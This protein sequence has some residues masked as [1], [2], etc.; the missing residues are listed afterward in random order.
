MIHRDSVA[1]QIVDSGMDSSRAPIALFVYNR[2]WH[3]RQTV[4][5]LQKNALASESDLIIFSDAPKSEA[6][7]DEVD[8]VRLYIRQVKGFRSISIIEREENFGLARSIIEGVTSITNKYGRIIVLEDDLVTSPY[9]LQFMNDALTVYRDDDNVMHISGYMYPVDR[10]DLPET[11]FLRPTSCWGWATW[12]RA[13]KH[14]EKTPKKF[15]AQYTKSE[16][17]RFNMD[18]TYDFWV[19]IQQNVSGTINTWAV[20]WYASVFRL[21]GLCLHPAFSMVNNIGHDATGE[22][23]SDNNDFSTAVADCPIRYFEKNIAENMLARTETKKYF[24]I[25][26]P[27]FFQRILRRLRV[28]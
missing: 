14:F 21:G 20:F 26:R 27:S 6:H 5:A 22:N 18:D 8:E 2:P 4:E 19:Q 23:C 17:S 1:N 10:S 28:A 25:I 16:I 15:L 24:Q 3:T 12:G 13:W 11:F 7:R 9:F